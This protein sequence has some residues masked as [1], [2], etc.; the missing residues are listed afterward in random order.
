[1]YYQKET[2]LKRKR[3]IYNFF[4]GVPGRPGDQGLEGQLG[5][6]GPEGLSGEKGEKGDVGIPGSRGSKGD[7]VSILFTLYYL[8]QPVSVYKDRIL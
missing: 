6:P 5:F 4:K 2:I 1:M 8:T 3:S 7:R